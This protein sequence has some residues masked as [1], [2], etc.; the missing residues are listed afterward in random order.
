M[1]IL[2]ATRAHEGLY[3]CVANNSIGTVVKNAQVE[4]I[5]RTIVRITEDQEM[6]VQAGGKLKLPCSV[7]H[8]PR[9]RLTSLVWTKDSEAISPGGEDRIDYGMDG[10]LSIFDVETRH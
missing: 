6:S 2:K 7:E 8:D 3:Q 9:N 5:S 4:V 10:S 1:R